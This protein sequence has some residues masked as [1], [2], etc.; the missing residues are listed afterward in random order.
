MVVWIFQFHPILTQKFISNLFD[1]PAY[2]LHLASCWQGNV[3]HV[4]CMVV[5]VDF[6]LKDYDVYNFG[7]SCFSF[8]FF[9]LHMGGRL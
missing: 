2:D 8:I 9:G 1:N 6:F 7:V 4:I 5:L 3:Y